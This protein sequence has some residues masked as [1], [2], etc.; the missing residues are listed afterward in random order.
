MAAFQIIDEVLEW[1]ACAAKTR[2][3]AHDLGIDNNDG[4]LRHVLIVSMPKL[5]APGTRLLRARPQ[6]WTLLEEAFDEWR[7]AFVPVTVDEAG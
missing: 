4:R 6:P 3:A 5:V 2:R 1:Y 7:V